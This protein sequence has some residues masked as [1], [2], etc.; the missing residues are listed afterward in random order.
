[1]AAHQA[2][3][4]PG[5]LQARSLEWSFLLQCIKVENQSEVAQ[6]C[7][8]LSDPMD[9]SLPVSSVHG[10]LQA[11]VGL[12]FF[13]FFFKCFVCFWLCWALVAARGIFSCGLGKEQ[14]GKMVVVRLSRPASSHSPSMFCK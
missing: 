1:M 4:V 14:V 5:I 11:G 13:F 10:I 7:P 3:P 2:P 6:S 8:T 12:P 9:G